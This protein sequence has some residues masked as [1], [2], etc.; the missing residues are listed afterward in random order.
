M[1]TE[2]MIEKFYND[3]AALMKKH[4][5]EADRFE[6]NQE[7]QQGR[8]YSA[9]RIETA[10]NPSEKKSLTKRIKEI[11]INYKKQMP[12]IE[13]G[14]IV[15]MEMH[16]DPKLNVEFVPEKV[17][18]LKLNKKKFSRIVQEQVND[19]VEK[20]A[21]RPKE[22]GPFNLTNIHKKRGGKIT[23]KKIEVVEGS[24]PVPVDVPVVQEEKVPEKKTGGGI[25]SRRELIKKIMK[26]KG[27]KMIEASK[28]IKENK[29]EY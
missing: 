22:E 24:V 27:M 23:E 6:I 2:A 19:V 13:G 5:Y 1:L 17:S 12:R 21:S 20:D 29:L 3:E 26:E 7:Q 11:E 9:G 18:G 10:G 16:D 4:A 8:Y 25:H 14:N 15:N 28:Y